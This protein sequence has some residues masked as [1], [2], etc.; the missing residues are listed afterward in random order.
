MEWLGFE[1]PQQTPEGDGEQINK[2]DWLTMTSS[3][4]IIFKTHSM[5]PT[6]LKGRQLLSLSRTHALSLSLSLSF[7][8]NFPAF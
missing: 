6:P 3:Q 1:Y 2:T 5:E 4:G 8:K 7:L